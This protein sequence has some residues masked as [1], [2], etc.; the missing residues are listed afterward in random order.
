MI[1]DKLVLIVIYQAAAAAKRNYI[2][3]GAWNK[4]LEVI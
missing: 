1:F 4:K 2:Y 3:K